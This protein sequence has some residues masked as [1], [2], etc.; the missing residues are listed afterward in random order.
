M[1]EREVL[2]DADVTIATVVPPTVLEETPGRRRRARPPTEPEVIAKG[3]G[4]EGEE[5]KKGT[6]DK[7]DKGKDKD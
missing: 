6:R 7:G 1:H 3:K 2:S 5:A 4:E